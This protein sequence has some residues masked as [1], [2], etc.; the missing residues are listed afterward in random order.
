MPVQ[1]TPDSAASSDRRQ[2]SIAR[3]H[4][5]LIQPVTSLDLR[6]FVFLAALQCVV[7]G[8]V[9]LGLRNNAHV[10]IP[11]LRHW[12]V[13]PLLALVSTLVYGLHGELSTVIVGNG[14]LMGAT[15]ALLA[16]TRLFLGRPWL[17]LMALCLSSLLA[18]TVIWPDYRARMLIFGLSMAA[19]CAAHTRTLALHTRG[20]PSRLMLVAMGWQTLVLL[21]RALSTYWL[22]SPSTGRFD[23][24]SLL[25]AVYIGT[26]SCSILVVL[27]GAQLMVNERVREKF[28]YLATHDDL[29]GV[30]NRRAIVRRIDQEHQHWLNEGRGYALILLDLDLCKRINDTFGHQVGDQTL[31]RVTKALTRGLRNTDRLGR[32]GGEEFIALLPATD[33]SAALGLAERLRTMVERMPRSGDEPACTV[34]IGLTVVQGGEKTPEAVLLR[35]DRALYKAKDAGRNQVAMAQ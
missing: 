30:L 25:Q 35:A 4:T 32:Y 13:A 2:V 33:L 10:P 24:G 7:M 14:F 12:G 26:Y 20:L 15:L 34:S 22:D 21:A 11:G 27:V 1:A 23:G 8:T 31:I 3:F 6:S 9:L 17:T 5:D 18:F 19:I 29:T 28:E 16:G